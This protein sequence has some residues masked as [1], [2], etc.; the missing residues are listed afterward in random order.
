M[1]DVGAVTVRAAGA[2][3]DLDALNAA[4]PA[5][6]GATVERGR[7]EAIDFAPSGVLVAER[8]GRPAGYGSYLAAGV[9]DGHRGSVSVY[10]PPADRGAGVGG[11]LWKAALSACPADLVRGVYLQL[12]EDDV[13]SRDIAL[14]HGLRLRGLHV[15][16]RLDLQA[17]DVAAL[18]R[19]AVAPAGLVIAP[20][21]V[22]ATD[23]HWREVVALGNRLLA[24]TP[25]MAAG[26]EPMPYAVVRS[27]LPQ[28]WQVMVAWDGA[29][30][31]GAT[32]VSVRSADDHEVNTLL[33]GVARD[34]RGRG[35]ATALKATH[36]LAL[37][38]A[39]WKSIRT[40]NM[41]GNVPIVAAN[42]TLGFTRF[43]SIR[44]ATWDHPVTA[45]TD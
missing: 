37:R 41:D 34:H 17:V 5:W 10:V 15:E 33:T 3:D 35:V 43:R 27:L 24:D 20:V 9:S 7:H 29:T 21:A 25:D 13:R 22:D 32:A 12:D 42:A 16:S 2:D 23:A 26:F 14:S 18:A 1:D 19:R 31:I 4:N 39:G 36:A 40:Q 38:A 28:S 8:G 11:A 30:M 6:L 45:G 44:D